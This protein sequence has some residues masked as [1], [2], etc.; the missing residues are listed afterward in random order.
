MFEFPRMRVRTQMLPPSKIT[1]S[2]SMNGIYALHMIMVYEEPPKTEKKVKKQ[3]F[4]QTSLNLLGT[5]RTRTRRNRKQKLGKW[6]WKRTCSS[7]N[8]GIEGCNNT[9]GGRNL[10]T[11]IHIDNSRKH[12]VCYLTRWNMGWDF[13]HSW[14]N[15]LTREYYL[16]S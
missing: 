6:Q 15:K 1:T 9:Q 2:W 10:I 14:T 11:G 3:L 13:W 5:V 12:V 8:L 4:V 16:R 7:P